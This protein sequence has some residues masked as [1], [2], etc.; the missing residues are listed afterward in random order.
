VAEA[1]RYS[2]TELEPSLGAASYMPLLPLSLLHNDQRITVSA[3]LDT[4]STVNVLPFNLGAQLGLAWDEQ[5]TPVQLT[6]NLAQ[7]EARGVLLTAQ[8]GSFDPVRLVFAWTRSDDVPPLL[9]QV[10]FFMEF[11][12]CFHRSQLAFEVRPK[13]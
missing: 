13:A 10:N 6:G 12:V 1:E 3:L 11:D 4:G 2:F 8:V 5:S 9:G 7:F